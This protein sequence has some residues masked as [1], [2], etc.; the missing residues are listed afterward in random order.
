MEFRGHYSWRLRSWEENIK[1]PKF[2]GAI[3]VKKGGARKN[4]D[5]TPK[6]L[7]KGPVVT[8]VSDF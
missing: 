5:Q 1:R 4:L 3:S 7:T 6:G 8:A 2:N